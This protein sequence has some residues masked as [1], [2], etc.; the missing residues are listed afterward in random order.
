MALGRTEQ[1]DKDHD[2]RFTTGKREKRYSHKKIKKM[3]HKYERHRAKADPECHPE[4]NKYA[5]WEW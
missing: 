2:K 5:G 1:I 4:Y 3:K